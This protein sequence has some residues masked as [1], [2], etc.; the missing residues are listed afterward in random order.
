MSRGVLTGLRARLE[1][2]RACEEGAAGAVTHFHGL[3]PSVQWVTK[4]LGRWMICVT[5][6]SL[7]LAER[8]T[9][10]NL[11]AANRA[12]QLS[13]PGRVQHVVRRCLDVGAMTTAKGAD[14]WTRRTLRISDS[15]MEMM[16]QRALVDMRAAL[17]LSPDLAD[18][19]PILSTNDGFGAYVVHIAEAATDDGQILLG[20]SRAGPL[21]HFLER[22]AGMLMLFALLGAQAPERCRLL[23]EARISRYALSRQYAISRAHI[24]TTLANSP[25]IAALTRDRVVF[26][27][28]LSEAVERHFEAVFR[29]NLA[30]AAALLRSTRTWSVPQP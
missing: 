26:S 14:S 28:A 22:E 10:R 15:F 5:A 8:L 4:D 23:E 6:V 29:V 21:N 1:F 11:T 25:D 9:V 16:K 20:P 27:E 2:R 18:A 3:D 17:I 12:I 19:L 7:H 30:A 24:N 13:S